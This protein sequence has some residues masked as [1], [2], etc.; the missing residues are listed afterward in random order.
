LG[1]NIVTDG[2]YNMSEHPNPYQF[3]KNITDMQIQNG[4]GKLIADIVFANNCSKGI[5]RD[6]K[7][8]VSISKVETNAPLLSF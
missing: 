8:N 2:D 4:G 5:K 6:K 7:S 3:P 1:N